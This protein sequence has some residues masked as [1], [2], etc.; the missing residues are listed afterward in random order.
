MAVEHSY[1]KGAWFSYK[2][3]PH[4][5]LSKTI[6]IQWQELFAIVAAAMTWWHLGSKRRICFHCDN[7]SI[8]LACQ[9]N[10]SKQPTFTTLLRKL[11]FD[12]AC[13]NFTVT[14]R[15]IPEIRNSIADAIS[16]MQF[17]QFSFLAPQASK[18]PT[19]TPGILTTF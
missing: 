2:W 1:Y 10:S 11:C 4:Q 19:P 8:A 7:Q 12:A 14:I 15:H 18:D 13:N 17:Q 3:R 5:C 16:R 9:G 6:S